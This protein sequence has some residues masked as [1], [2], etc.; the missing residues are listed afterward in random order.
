MA[1]VTDLNRDMADHRN[2]DVAF[3]E[4]FPVLPLSELDSF[5]TWAR[6]DHQAGDAHVVPWLDPPSDRA[7]VQAWI[8]LFPVQVASAAER[9]VVQW[10]RGSHDLRITTIDG[11]Y[12]ELAE[13]DE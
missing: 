10:L 1:T 7:E 11:L 6:W 4:E 5:V 8:D 12:E 9:A 13:G 3:D 2:N